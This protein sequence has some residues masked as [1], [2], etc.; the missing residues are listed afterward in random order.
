MSKFQPVKGMRDFWP[1]EMLKREFVLD[2]MKKAAQKWGFLPSDTPAVESFDLL[3]AKGGAGDAIK[4]ELYYFKDQGDRELGL[5]FDLTVP[6]A[7]L[8]SSKL[9]LSL[10]F[11]RYTTGK[12][13]RYDNPQALRWREFQQFDI[14]IFGSTKPEADAEI[15]ALTCE[16][17]S[18]LGFKDFVVSLNSRKL[19]E[20]F[21]KSVGIAD[22][23]E[24]FRSIDKLDKI[25]EDG[26]RKELAEKISE[27]NKIEKIIGFI[28]IRGF[29]AFEKAVKGI[30]GSEAKRAAEE[31]KNISR[32]IENFGYKNIQLDMSL[33]RGLEYYTGIVFEV[34][35]PG[36]PVSLG[37]GG[38]YDNMIESFGGRNTPAIGVGIG[39][40]RIV[41]IMSQKGMFKL[42]PP[43][44]LFVVSVSD[45]V[46]PEA[47]KICQQLRAEGI[48]SIFDISGKDLKKQ[49]GYANSS[50]IPFVLFVGEKELKEEKFKLKSMKNG[51]ERTGSLEDLIKVLKEG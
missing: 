14:D 29:E 3:C 10:P 21:L 24:I 44:K 13:W 20:A 39:F 23:P 43:V 38:R 33:V 36:T 40:E 4:K 25:G 27:K 37:G 17:F 31:L 18:S 47:L 32:L 9:D 35:V 19:L 41:E 51:N 7:R 11:K 5:R 50:G 28:K 12:V 34:R 26:V 8:V 22:L 48:S 1:A 15:I 16:I 49:L 42:E 30:K 6:T 46:R 45:G 2:I